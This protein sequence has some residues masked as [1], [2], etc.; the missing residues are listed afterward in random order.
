MRNRETVSTALFC[1]K[2]PGKDSIEENIGGENMQP[3]IDLDK[4][5]GIVLEGG[6]AKGA[7]QVGAWQALKKAG[8]KIKRMLVPA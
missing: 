2:Y 7:Y 6:G 5:Y 1:H 3:V 4:E 8:I